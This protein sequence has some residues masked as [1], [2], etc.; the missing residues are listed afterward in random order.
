MCVNGE[1]INSLLSTCI[2][3]FLYSDCILVK[4]SWTIIKNTLAYIMT[5]TCISRF[6]IVS[7]SKY[8]GTFILM[9]KSMNHHLHIDFMWATSTLMIAIYEEEILFFFSGLQSH[10]DHGTWGACFISSCL[11]CQDV[12]FSFPS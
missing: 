6:E 11:E 7:L 9:H 8:L 10:E 2:F 4:I 5:Y 1:I 12:L 3:K